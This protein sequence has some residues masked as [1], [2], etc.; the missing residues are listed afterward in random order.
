MKEEKLEEKR[1][2]DSKKYRIGDEKLKLLEQ[3]ER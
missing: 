3:K 1:I 2:R